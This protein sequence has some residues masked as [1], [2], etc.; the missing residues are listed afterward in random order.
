MSV[1]DSV[2]DVLG[3]AAEVISVSALEDMSRAAMRSLQEKGDSS[4][5]RLHES[6][7][8]NLPLA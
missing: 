8:R 3:I 5:Q 7:E 1:D 4:Q 2:A 6:P